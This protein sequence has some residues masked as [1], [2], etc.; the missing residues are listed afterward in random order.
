MFWGCRV[1]KH[2]GSA[3]VLE[4]ARGPLPKSECRSRQ[5]RQEKGMYM[6]GGGG[7]HMYLYT[8]SY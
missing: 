7:H 6:G 1:P 5:E 2:P 4:S 8:N 3:T